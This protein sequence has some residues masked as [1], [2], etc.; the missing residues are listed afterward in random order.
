M[1]SGLARK[2]KLEAKRQGGRE[3]KEVKEAKEVEEV[4]EAGLHKAKTEDRRPKT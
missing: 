4:K 1:K 3:A 2:P